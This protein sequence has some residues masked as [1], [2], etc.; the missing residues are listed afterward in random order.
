MI[1]ISKTFHNI[2]NITKPSKETPYD[3]AKSNL[4]LQLCL[5]PPS[6]LEKLEK[7]WT[8]REQQ[9]PTSSR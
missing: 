7:V 6:D 5:D 4:L 1:V 3:K 9:A 2:V 8:K